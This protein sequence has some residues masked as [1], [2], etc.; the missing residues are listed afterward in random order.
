MPEIMKAG[1]R[2]SGFPRTPLETSVY[3]AL[4]NVPAKLIREDIVLI[5][6]PCLTGSQAPF[7]LFRLH[8]AQ[9]VDHIRRHHEGPLL[10]IFQG[11]KMIFAL[12]FPFLLQLPVYPDGVLL[13]VDAVPCQSDHLALAEAGKR[14]YIEQRLQRISLDSI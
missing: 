3:R 8:L 2:N 5:A 12:W 9:N 7:R 6:F 13:K 1:H 4:G 11:N 10:V 14:R